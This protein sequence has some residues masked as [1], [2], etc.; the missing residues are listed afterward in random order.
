MTPKGHLP[1]NIPASIRAKLLNMSR[2]TGENFQFLLDRFARER[3]L[4]RLSRSQYHKRFILKGA[5]LF[6]IWAERPFRSTRDVDFLAFGPNEVDAV[7]AI[8]RDLCDAEPENITADDG[9]R[10]DPNSVHGEVLRKEKGYSGVRVRLTAYLDNA[11]ANVQI[12]VGFGDAVTPKAQNVD[13]PVILDLP[14]PRMLAYPKETVVAEKF[15]AIIILTETNSRMKDFY[16]LWV[17]QDEF[18]FDGQTLSAAI[19]ATFSRRETNIAPN[20]CIAFQASFYA[21]EKL[22]M[23]W[24]AYVQRGSFE[25]IPP[26][27]AEIGEAISAFLRPVAESIAIGEQFNQIWAPGG[28]WKTKEK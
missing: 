1:K 12:D 19:E 4:Y 16:D 9:I 5:T 23:R 18:E 21:N 24:R 8:F 2:E 14:S 3:L 17:L 13:V 10:F 26:S 6:E 25:K 11:R 20:S 27:F 15:Q 7:V 28:P 22:L